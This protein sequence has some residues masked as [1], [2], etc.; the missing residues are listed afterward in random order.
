VP[1]CPLTRHLELGSLDLQTGHECGLQVKKGKKRASKYPWESHLK[2]IAQMCILEM[3]TD[4]QRPTPPHSA[5]T[6]GPTEILELTAE[7]DGGRV[8]L[9]SAK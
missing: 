5:R 3:E 4:Q 2:P 1:G 9:S 7:A 8:P 6:E